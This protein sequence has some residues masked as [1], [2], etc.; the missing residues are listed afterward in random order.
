MDDDKKWRGQNAAEIVTQD[1]LQELDRANVLED[2]LFER[3]RQDELW[4][5]QSGHANE[6]WL[7]ILIEEVGEVARAMYDD[8][9]GHTYEEIIQ[10]AAVCMA[11]AEAMQKRKNNGKQ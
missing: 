8:D 10:C 4:G 2:V 6:R 5:D 3:L 7:V 1:F 9:E 11:W